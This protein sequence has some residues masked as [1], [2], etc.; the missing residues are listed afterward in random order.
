MDRA[1]YRWKDDDRCLD[2]KWENG[3]KNG[4]REYVDRW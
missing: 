1:M 2:G 3:W 4:W